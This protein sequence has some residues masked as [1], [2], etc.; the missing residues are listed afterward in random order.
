[1]TEQSLYILKLAA[2]RYASSRSLENR[3][4][5]LA[6]GSILWEGFPDFLV[7]MKEAIQAGHGKEFLRRDDIKHLYALL[8]VGTLNGLDAD[9][10]A[11][12]SGALHDA[13]DQP[14]ALMAG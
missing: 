2:K 11:K 10:L 7:E 5:M 13:A 9:S 4:A 3:I 6:I 1:M 14:Q 8:F 12:I